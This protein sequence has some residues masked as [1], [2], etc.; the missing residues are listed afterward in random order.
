[1][2]RLVVKIIGENAGDGSEM[3]LASVESDKYSPSHVDDLIGDAI[4]RVLKGRGLTRISDLRELSPE[5]SVR[6]FADDVACRPSLHFCQDTI[7]KM[8]EAGAS[9]DFDPYV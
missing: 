9:F 5:I 7:S 8:A 6:L 1:M 4:I 2:L 3:I